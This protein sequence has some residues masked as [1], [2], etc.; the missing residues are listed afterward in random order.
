MPKPPPLATPLVDMS[1]AHNYKG[2]DGGL[3]GNGLNE[4]PSA[5]RSTALK[6]LA[7]IEPLDARGVPST[8][9]QTV[10]I[11]IGMSNTRQEFGRF[12]QL[13]DT[14]S[15]KSSNLVIVNGAASGMDARVWA[16][17][18][19]PWQGL[20]QQ[21]DI[22]GIT[23][24]QVQVAWIKQA[25]AFPREP[26]PTEARTLQGHLTIIVTLLK[27][28]YPNL[29]VVYFSSRIYAGYATGHSTPS[30]MLLRGP[31]PYAG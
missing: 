15:D 11:S 26:F 22:R 18:D 13:A 10:L 5:H 6:E 23:P 16:T 25:N 19:S 8:D 30:L 31:L 28:R 24:P 21:L 29:R 20:E 12:Q 3:Y 14:D 2:E 4:P 17:T 27:E 1:A 7:K 9:G